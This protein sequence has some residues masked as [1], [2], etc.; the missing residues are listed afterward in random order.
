MKF[1]DEELPNLNRDSKYLEYYINLSQYRIIFLSEEITK[2]TA[3]TLSALLLHYDSENNNDIILYINSPGGDASALINICDTMKTIKSPINTVC[4]G[5]CFSAAAIILCAGTKGKR[6]ATKNSQIMIHGLQ[7]MFPL[8]PNSDQKDSEI[9]YNFLKRY[10]NIVLGILAK[11]S[12][13]TLK[14]IERD[15]KRD[16]WMDAKEALKYGIIDH[17]L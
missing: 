7:C 2:N 8:T 11:H 10:N 9:Y 1:N 5:G 15:C 6:F 16:L 17:I 3:S 13:K 14:Q 12:K 4:L